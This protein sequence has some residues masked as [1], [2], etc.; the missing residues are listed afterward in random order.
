MH[1]ITALVFL[2]LFAAMQY[3]KLIS[4]LNCKV[5]STRTVHCDCE[6]I[7]TDSNGN[8]ATN[9]Q[10]NQ[11]KDKMEDWYTWST[12]LPNA[13]KVCPVFTHPISNHTSFRTNGFNKVIFQPPRIS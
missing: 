11:V 7:L 4:Y 13:A 10:A 9:L 6:K 8:A 12:T 2:A 5:T 1:K 3:G